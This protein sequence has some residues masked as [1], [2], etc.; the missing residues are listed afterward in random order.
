MHSQAENN[1]C[2]I[3]ININGLLNKTFKLET[4][5][6]NFPYCKFLCI[7]EHHLVSSDYKSFIM[8]NFKIASI[9]SRNSS[10][11]GSL[12]L[13]KNID[14]T[15]RTDI[16]LCSQSGHIECSAIDTKFN[17]EFVTVLCVYRPPSGNFSI[18]TT[19]LKKI[20]ALCNKQ[21]KKVILTGDFNINLMENCNKSM[22]FLEILSLNN[23]TPLISEPTRIT[24]NSSTLIDNIIVSNNLLY[25]VVK[26]YVEDLYLSDHRAVLIDLIHNNMDKIP[27]KKYCR[28]YSNK[29]IAKFNEILKHEKW[30]KIINLEC[31]DINVLF[32]EFHDKYIAHFND[33]FPVK[34]KKIPKKQLNHDWKTTGLKISQKKLR[35]LPKLKNVDPK[36]YSKEYVKR[37]HKIYHSL[38][39]LSKS[40]VNSNKINTAENK[41]K[42]MWDLIKLRHC[43]S[44]T[45]C[46]IDKIIYNGIDI[47]DQNEIVNTFS[48]YFIKTVDDIKEITNVKKIENPNLNFNFPCN[49]SSMFFYPIT[50][51]E[52]TEIINNLKPKSSYG[53]D[54]VPDFIFKKCS[55]GVIEIL[56]FLINKSVTLG[57]FPDILK[58]SIIRPIFKKGDKH[59]ISNYRPISLL[60]VYSKIF[61]KAFLKRLLSFIQKHDIF[62]KHQHGFRQSLSTESAIFNLIN[63]ILDDI[64]KKNKTAGIFLDLTKAF[65]C[66]DHDI[67]L[68][69]LQRYGIRGNCL[70]WLASY[71]S[72]RN[73][74]V[75]LRAFDS[76]GIET[77]HKSEKQD[78]KYGVPQGSILGPVLFLLYVNDLPDYCLLLSCK[79]TL[80][81]DDSTVQ[82]T[83]VD[84]EDLKN[85]IINIIPKIE[86]WF[87]SNGLLMNRSKT[88]IISFNPIQNLNYLTG[89]ID[90]ETD[91]FSC[92]EHAKFLG[93]HVD[94]N[95]RWTAHTDYLRKKLPSVI[96]ALNE[97][98]NSISLNSLKALYF[99]NF[100][101]LLSYGVI[102]W[103]NNIDSLHIFILQKKALRTMLKLKKLTS[104]KN[105]FIQE[106][107]L[108]LP[109]LYIYQC[110]S[111]VKKNYNEFYCEP[112]YEYN[113]RNKRMLRPPTS[114]IQL[115]ENGP[116]CQCMIL[117][118]KLPE[119]LKHIT[120]YKIF[121][122]ESKKFLIENCFYDVREYT[123]FQ[124]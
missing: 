61:E 62:S 31:D 56:T 118:N 60:S 123:D 40:I 68:K 104:C 91:S 20:I 99:S 45:G 122:K 12:I 90:T 105:Y 89:S 7:T 44:K 34:L 102:F 14:F 23:L 85:K 15:R 38:V 43:N 33:C 13:T 17:M 93:V 74:T 116:L 75:V 53:F 29:N 76:N 111:Y 57:I 87:T 21:K 109:S 110:I 70:S 19:Q 49:I 22:E 58:Q 73:H 65:D 100:H 63:G 41:S 35:L 9:F 78:V 71:L 46:D 88:E 36:T 95:L 96:F 83:S 51:S 26:S 59:D 98:K 47:M 66:V 25:L 81:A 124:Q 113:T 10:W 86:Q 30:D 3:H 28:S 54:E 64:N 5:L 119:Y 8:N 79:P 48:K 115:V 42:A 108:T 11:G 80:F 97:L 101:S 117:Y 121:R 120:D 72:N 82:I 92:V 52:I 6:Q 1:T 106:N 24:E 32:N 50:S 4:T 18:F 2:L 39:K 84:N 103:G 77:I 69:K 55:D 37:Y 114:R 67:L 107:I 27:K 16:E 94:R 112:K